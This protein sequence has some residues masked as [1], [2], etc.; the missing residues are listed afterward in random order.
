MVVKYPFLLSAFLAVFLI[1]CQNVKAVSE[2]VFHIADFPDDVRHQALSGGRLKVMIPKG[3]VISSAAYY[4][5]GIASGPDQDQISAGRIIDKKDIHTSAARARHLSMA[6]FPE[7]KGQENILGVAQGAR[8][9]YAILSESFWGQVEDGLSSLDLKGKRAEP[10]YLIM[11]LQPSD[12][13]IGEFEFG[14]IIEKQFGQGA[15]QVNER[16][17][18]R[19][20]EHWA[21]QFCLKLFRM[22]RCA[23]TLE[24]DGDDAGSVIVAIN[25]G[26]E[27]ETVIHFVNPNAD[28]DHDIY[29][30][31]LGPVRENP[32]YKPLFFEK[33]VDEDNSGQLALF[34]EPAFAPDGGQCPL[35]ISEGGHLQIV[36]VNAEDL[37][38][39]A[40]GAAAIPST[41][42]KKNPFVCFDGTQGF[43]EGIYVT[44]PNREFSIVTGSKFWKLSVDASASYGEKKEIVED[45][46]DQLPNALGGKPTFLPRRTA[47]PTRPKKNAVVVETRQVI[48]EGDTLDGHVLDERALDEDCYM[49]MTNGNEESNRNSYGSAGKRNDSTGSSGSGAAPLLKVNT[50]IDSVSHLEEVKR[51]DQIFSFGKQTL[52]EISLKHN[53]YHKQE[54]LFSEKSPV[55]AVHVAQYILS[56]ERGGRVSDR[57]GKVQ[58]TKGKQTEEPLWVTVNQVVGKLRSEYDPSYF[59]KGRCLYCNGTFV[60]DDLCKSLTYYPALVSEAF[61]GNKK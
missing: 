48:K 36:R 14:S 15:L 53:V 18:N 34:V 28:R 47:K 44:P 35:V 50:D 37:A 25:V 30:E 22:F 31:S 52:I 11:L 49:I 21:I 24:V 42:G 58:K 57:K 40:E 39:S 29:H 56:D 46:M 10:F 9:H 60:D 17:L 27:G 41:P 19:V 13:N 16:V 23:R 51:Y 5:G 32:E 59:Q 4:S 3:G 55:Q 8:L 20:S 1:V 26:D 61:V 38:F 54:I 45:V 33:K 2:V 43:E 12:E 6:V 7:P